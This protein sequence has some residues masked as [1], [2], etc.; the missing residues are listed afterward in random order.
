MTTTD[1]IVPISDLRIRQADVLS[2]LANGPVYLMQRSKPAAVLLSNNVWNQLVQRLENQDDLISALKAE[3]AIAN[4][5]YVP[6]A[7]DFEALEAEV[8]SDAIPA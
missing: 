4:G 2:R 8:D 3:L 6:E 1:Q 7:I 5:E